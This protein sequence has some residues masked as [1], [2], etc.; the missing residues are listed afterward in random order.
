M[1]FVSNHS[2]IITDKIG[3]EYAYKLGLMR[4]GFDGVKNLSL[5][6]ILLMVSYLASDRFHTNFLQCVIAIPISVAHP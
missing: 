1:D 4:V 5:R 3:I 6:Q 2:R